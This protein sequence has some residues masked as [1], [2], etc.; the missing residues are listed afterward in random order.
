MSLQN[1][2]RTSAAFHYLWLRRR[3]IYGA[4]MVVA[5][6]R[7]PARVRFRLVAPVCDVHLTLANA[8]RSMTKVP[9]LALFAAFFVLTVL[10]FDHLNARTLRWSLLATILLGLLVE[11]EEGASRTGN[12]RITDVLPD[13]IGAG[14]A[15]TLL[16]GGALLLGMSRRV[17]TPGA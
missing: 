17:R 4:Y 1:Q 10:Q 3:W 7:I 14:I 13:I 2:S 16:F 5:V 12:C 9:H 6:L 15:A 8:G 11:L